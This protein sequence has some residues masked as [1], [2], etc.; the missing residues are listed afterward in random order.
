LIEIYARLIE[1][2]L[3]C[4]PADEEPEFLVPGTEPGG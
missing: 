1:E 4:K 3:A 2:E